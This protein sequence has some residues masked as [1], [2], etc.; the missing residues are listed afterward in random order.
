MAATNMYID[1]YRVTMIKIFIA[2][3]RAPTSL[4]WLN[5]A[6]LAPNSFY[7]AELILAPPGLYWFHLAYTDSARL[8]L[9]RPGLYW[10]HLAYT[11]STWLTLAQPGVYRLH[12][13][14]LHLAYICS[15]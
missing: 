3:S 12:L 11:S 8:T 15:T 10:L 9:A 5:L 14:G 7:S 4:Y 13:H 6:L 2:L 1:H